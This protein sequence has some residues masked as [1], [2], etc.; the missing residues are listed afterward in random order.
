MLSTGW[1]YILS[2]ESM[3]GVV[4]IG[5]T[6]DLP[7]HRAAELSSTGVPSPFV[8]EAAF[9]FADKA[10]KIE[11][12]THKHLE[13]KRVTPNREFFKVSASD[14]SVAINKIALSLREEI[15]KSDPPLKSR[16][17][18]RGQ[19]E[20]DY[21]KRRAERLAISAMG[22]AASIREIKTALY[23]IKHVSSLDDDGATYVNGVGFSGVDTDYGRRLASKPHTNLTH[24]EQG[25]V[26][27]LAYKY[28]KQAPS[29]LI[30][31]LQK[32]IIEHK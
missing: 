7:K 30:N 20:S 2:N 22:K 5:V 12:L 15:L 3:P 14:A 19:E 10:L 21:D 28:R 32:P 13:S 9:L 23:C 31:Q 25:R 6:A 24:L 18:T 29:H 26:L 8:V 1:V 27:Q 11:Q 16:Y 17:A 4:K